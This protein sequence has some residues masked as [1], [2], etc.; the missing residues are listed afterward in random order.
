[1]TK[2]VPKLWLKFDDTFNQGSW[3][4]PDPNDPNV[5]QAREFI[6]IS[7]SIGWH[8]C[9]QIASG[10]KKCEFKSGNM[11]ELIYEQSHQTLE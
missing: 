8:I 3:D 6:R 5:N 4:L 9:Y 1:M 2:S 11:P 7:A 10:A